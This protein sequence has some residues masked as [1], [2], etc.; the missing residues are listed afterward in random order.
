MGTTRVMQRLRLTPLMQRIYE[1]NITSV[2]EIS[3]AALEEGDVH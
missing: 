1:G 3:A 2:G